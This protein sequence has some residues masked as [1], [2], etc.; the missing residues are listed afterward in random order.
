MEVW[1]SFK[2]ACLGGR[3]EV[4]VGNDLVEVPITPGAQTGRVVSYRGRQ[5]KLMVEESDTFLRNGL[6]LHLT[7]VIEE[8]DAE[9]GCDRTI[10]TLEKHRRIEIPDGTQDGDTVRLQGLGIRVPGEVGDLVIDVVVKPSE[11]P[12]GYGRVR[13]RATKKASKGMRPTARPPRRAPADDRPPPAEGDAGMVH[14]GPAED[15][16]ED[17][18]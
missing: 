7:L 14:I 11:G 18:D 3:Q 10:P 12:K 1:V 13:M 16:D 5:F 6:D 4:L 17:D 2:L 8:H 15:D 9:R